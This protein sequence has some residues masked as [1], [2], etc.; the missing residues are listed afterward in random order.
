V[1]NKLRLNVI[2]LLNH[3]WPGASQAIARTAYHLSEAEQVYNDAIARQ[4]QAVSTVQGDVTQV[5]LPALLRCPSPES[6]IHELLAP[7]GF[8]ATQCRQVLESV[9][10]KAV[11]RQFL[12]DQAQVVVDR[13][14]LFMAPLPEELPVMR[15]PEAGVYHYGKEM[16]IAVTVAQ[17]VEVSR[18]P[19]VATLDADLAAFP[20]TVR[21]VLSGERFQ[22]FGM[23]GQ[24][25]VSD[26]LTDSK[27]PL[28]ERQRQL[29]VTAADGRIIWLVGRR[30]DQRAAITAA[31]KSVLKLSIV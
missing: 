12:S 5:S 9:E 23:R 13:E 20:L 10:K 21:P 18:Q 25:L 3:V 2:P 7:R 15:I 24:K 26:Y 4:L 11:G 28:V 29:V 27:V 1:R 31:T 16:K 6:V 8:S 17:T 22:P 19:S 14:Q 30:T